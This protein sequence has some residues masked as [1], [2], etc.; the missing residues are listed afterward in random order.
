M[1]CSGCFRDNKN[2]IS[3]AGTLNN[4]TNLGWYSLEMNIKVEYGLYLNSQVDQLKP[5]DG[6]SELGSA[7]HYNAGIS[8]NELFVAYDEGGDK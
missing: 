2:K 6:R 1:N 5:L 3:T 8:A 7:F 4:L